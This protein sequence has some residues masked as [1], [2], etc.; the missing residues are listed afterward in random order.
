[1]KTKDAHEIVT[2][3]IIMLPSKLYDNSEDCKDAI[4]S[5][6]ELKKNVATDENSLEKVLD[7]NFTGCLTETKR[8]DNGSISGGT[9]T[10]DCAHEDDSR[11]IDT[12]DDVATAEDM[13]EDTLSDYSPIPALQTQGKKSCTFGRFRRK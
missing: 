6:G 2:E 13:D 9:L 3:E 8:I 11:C 7:I 10:K 1:M 5:N 4:H 12:L